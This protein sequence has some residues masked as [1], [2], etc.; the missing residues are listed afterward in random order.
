MKHIYKAIA[1]GMA[2]LPTAAMAQ[3]DADYVNDSLNNKVNVAFRTVDKSDLM[4]GVSSINMVEL[5][6]KNYTTYSL[7]NMQ[8][9][10]GGYT[11]QLWNMGDALVIVDGVPRDANNVLPSEIE[12]IT[13]LKS[14]SAVVLYGSR[15]AKGAI[16]ITTKRGRNEGLK[17][18][19]RGNATIYTPK[20]YP[21]YLS[22]APYMKLYNEARLND[23][24]TAA[25]SENEIY[26]Y[27]QGDNP[28]RYPSINFFSNDYLSKTYQRYEGIA[29]FSGG[30]QYAHFY[31]NVG[32]YHN[33]DLLNFGEGKNNGTTRLNVRGNIDLRLNDWIT[34]YVNANATFYD[35]RSDRS[36]FWAQSA[37]ITPTSQNPLTP[38]I[39]ISA[40][41]LNDAE[42]LRLYEGSNYIVDGQYLLGGTQNQKTNPFAAMYVAG[43]DKYT[44]RQ[45]Q[46]D[47]GINFDLNS[48]L[49]GLSFKTKFAVDY[50]T[51]YNTYMDNQ[52]AT[53]EPVWD[54]NKYNKVTKLNKYNVDKRTGIP[55]RGGTTY[56]QMILWQGQFDY[57]RSFGLHNVDATFLAHGY[58]QSIAGEYHRI[59]NA[60]LGLNVG[61]NYNKTYYAELSM[62]A[63]HSAKLAEGH[64]EAVSPV[65]SAA[66]RISNEK[67]M[68]GTKSWLD[69]LKINASYGIIN[70][71]LDIENYYM[72]DNIFT[73]TG[74]WWG[75]SESANSMQTSDSQRG[76]NYELGFVKRKEFRAGIDASLWN[77]LITLNANYFNVKFDGL[78]TT[79]EAQMPSYYHTYWPTSTFLAYMNY[80]IQS[81]SGFDFTVNVHK[82]F[83]EVDLQA[84]FTG[85]VYDCKNDRIS[86]NVAHE[87][88]KSEGQRIDALRGYKCLGFMTE[89]DMKEE[90]GKKVPAIAT[91]NNYAQPGDL[92]YEDMNGDGI[93]DSKDQVVLGKWTPDVTLGFNFTAKYKNFTLFLNATGNFGASA[94]KNNSYEWCETGKYS[95]V[96]LNR[97]TPETAA[98]ATYPRLSLEHSDLNYV[99]SDFWTYKTDAVRL[100]KVQLTY[101]FPTTM[102]Q[103]SFVKGLQLY[104]YG[105]DLL[106]I[107]KERKY[108]ET[109]VGSAPQCRSYNLGVKVNF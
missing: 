66:W 23:G 93:I 106:T 102:F 57:N 53:Y 84:G 5:T 11:G 40:L 36:D 1:L 68:E 107:A 33:N 73:A 14:A 29:E 46:F 76:A 64:R 6:H 100:N 89:A 59:S 104:V 80:N 17:V 35:L 70:E 83:G 103:N 55:V 82:Q 15:A 81:R 38:L 12:Q 63:I 28:Y 86:E 77:G 101:D 21:T 3:D 34:G 79:P 24:N 90:N 22:S 67:F 45:M 71:D 42:Q 32:L 95:D 105:A 37:K 26:A 30:G 58:Q 78:L 74:T 60:N 13:F 54:T 97:W 39:P 4:G 9:Y 43:W 51:T 19:V 62:A 8:A 88:L 92:K 31:A 18:S 109:A 16:L 56:K 10:V 98:T 41:N 47:M 48:V 50:A 75:W 49:K 91:I 52:Y 85:M 2:L 96:L 72:Y 20:E 65:A 87:W 25:Y 61:Y 94:V 7:D 69:D 99:T 108:M 44:S 27:A